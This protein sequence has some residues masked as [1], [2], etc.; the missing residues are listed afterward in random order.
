[1]GNKLTILIFYYS[2]FLSC[3][4]LWALPQN[5]LQIY[6]LKFWVLENKRFP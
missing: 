4:Q 6:P 1:M 5:L 3:K 2:W